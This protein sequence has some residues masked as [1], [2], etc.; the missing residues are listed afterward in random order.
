MEGDRQPEQEPKYAS[1]R[2]EVLHRLALEGWANESA[3]DREHEAG[4]FARITVERAE[5]S[6]VAEAFA[7][8]I[9]AAGLTEPDQLIG[10]YLLVEGQGDHIDVHVFDSEPELR[11]VFSGLERAWREAE[12]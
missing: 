4:F 9:E 1:A 8:A 10:H 11:F 6:E 3:G 2:D 12:S 5:L 7:E